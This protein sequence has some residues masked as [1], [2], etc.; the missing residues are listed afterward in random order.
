MADALT[1]PINQSVDRCAS[2]LTCN[3]SQSTKV[4]TLAAARS[5][6]TSADSHANS[7]STPCESATQ[8]ILTNR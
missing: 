5:A 3:F 8:A 1:S 6:A 2:P 7:A 4:S